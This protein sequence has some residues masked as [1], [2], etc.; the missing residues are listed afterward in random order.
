MLS[1]AKL[2][3]SFDPV[4]LQSD[5]DRVFPEDWVRHFNDRYFEGDWSGVALRVVGGTSKQLYSDPTNSEDPVDTPVLARCPSLRHVL[6]ALECSV[7]SARLLKLGSGSRILEH[8]DYNLSLDDE[9]AR[10]HVVIT[11]GP[12]V[13]FFLN[14]ERLDMNPGEC[15]Y[16]NA[17]LPHKVHN[18]GETDRVH[19]VVDCKVDDRLLSLVASAVGQVEAPAAF[20]QSEPRASAPEA[21]TQFCE[22]VFEDL[23]LQEPLREAIDKD[24]FR[25]LVV[26]LGAEHGFYFNERDVEDAFRA[27]RRGWIERWLKT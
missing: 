6:Q 10:L 3:L 16:I 18:R 23:G 11:T 27:R 12:A 9:E 7:K 4:D 25:K 1:C 21:L 15:W 24:L 19:L 14:G 2:P 8:R 5:L 26:R 13:D 20:G 17:N 22:L